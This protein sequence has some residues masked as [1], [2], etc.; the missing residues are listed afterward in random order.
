MFLSLCDW[1]GTN[2]LFA[3]LGF[4]NRMYSLTKSWMEL[5][6]WLKPPPLLC[7]GAQ[8]QFHFNSDLIAKK[9]E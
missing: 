6:G 1:R 9:R 5:A 3:P 8:F 4:D 2:Q 7:F